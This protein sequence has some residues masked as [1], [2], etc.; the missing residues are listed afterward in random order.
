MTTAPTDAAV[1]G[2]RNP[3]R[4]AFVVSDSTGITAETLAGALL[5]S[6]PELRFERRTIPFVTDEASARAAATEIDRASRRGIRPIVFLTVADELVRKIIGSS[7]A[8]VVDLF[9]DHLHELETALETTAAGHS[10]SHHDDTEGRRHRKRM[11]AVQFAIEHDDG[12]NS[13]ALGDAE[14]IIIAP[15]RCGKTETAMYLAVQYGLLVAN[16]PLTDDPTENGGGIPTPVLPHIRRCFGLTTTPLRLHQ[17]RSK[18]WPN[19]AYASLQQCT[20][21]LRRAEGVYRGHGIPFLSSAATSVEEA[22]A[23]IL[24]AMKLRSEPL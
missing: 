10:Q 8:V 1:A 15:S 19:S 12:Q 13:A 21:E 7:A 20:R 4:A 16:V 6:F 2:S 5:S 3:G 9:G 24:R 17:V 23:T 22:S 11:R 14:L 18:R